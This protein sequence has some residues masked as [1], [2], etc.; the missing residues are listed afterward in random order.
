MGQNQRR[1]PAI[2]EDIFIRRATPRTGFFGLLPT[3]I[4]AAAVTPVILFNVVRPVDAA[5]GR[6]VAPQFYGFLP[7]APAAAAASPV[8]AIRQAQL[9]Y[10][11][12][13][14]VDVRPQF[15]QFPYF[16]Q[17]Q[18]PPNVLIKILVAQQTGDAPPPRPVPA[19]FYGFVPPIPAPANPVIPF[20]RG[21]YLGEGRVELHVRP[22]FIPFLPFSP[23][24]VAPANPVIPIT[25]SRWKGDEPVPLHVRPQFI[26][27]TPPELPANPVIPF[28][29]GRLIG[30]ERAPLHVRP[31]FYP[32]VPPTEAAAN[33]VIAILRA[34]LV[35]D[36]RQPLFVR[37]QFI[38]FTSPTVEAAASPVIPFVLVRDL[39]A[40]PPSVFTQPR[41]LPFP[42]FAQPEAAANPVIP[43]RQ[44]PW[45]AFGELEKRTTASPRYFPFIVFPFPLETFVTYE[46][47]LQ[48][49]A[50]QYTPAGTIYFEVILKSQAGAEVKARL[51]NIT[52]SVA[53]GSSEI[54]T[55]STTA[56]RLRS[57]ALTLSG[58]KE[59]RAEVRVTAGET[60]SIR[61][62]R[63]I[64]QQ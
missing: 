37:P 39:G 52:D 40:Q 29:F 26:A 61:S 27:F 9:V 13:E 64:V 56:T 51:F 22:Q 53:V 18:Q 45:L 32:L 42:Y 6:M 63:L 8:I 20:I 10:D 23:G 49:D 47:F 28:T 5:P 17:T 3:F 25:V 58:V 12:R 55:T 57:V 43:I 1:A 41:Y 30:D 35:G 50:A 24:V 33:P 54:T 59:Y 46:A 31:R 21:Q 19:Q 34:Q 11:G 2:L 36:E 44:T 62:A 14:R 4:A 7:P 38:Q 15:F 16:D 60:T 48:F